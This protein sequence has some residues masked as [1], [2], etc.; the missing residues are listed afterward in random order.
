MADFSI[1]KPS[2][3]RFIGSAHADPYAATDFDL[4]I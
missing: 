2:R 1:A 4:S 3:R